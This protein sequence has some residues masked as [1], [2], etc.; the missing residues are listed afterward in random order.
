MCLWLQHHRFAME[1]FEQVFEAVRQVPLVKQSYTTEQLDKQLSAFKEVVDSPAQFMA[2]HNDADMQ[3]SLQVSMKA[4]GVSACVVATVFKHC[5][6]ISDLV[7]D[8]DL[9]A[10]SPPV[11]QPDQPQPQAQPALTDVTGLMQFLPSAANRKQL[12]QPQRLQPPQ[13][14]GDPQPVNDAVL[15][16]HVC[17]AST[18][19]AS[20][21]VTKIKQDM[22]EDPNIMDSD[23]SHPTTT[24]RNMC[25]QPPFTADVIKKINLHCI[26]KLGKDV[27]VQLAA[28][29]SFLFRDKKDVNHTRGL[30]FSQLKNGIGRVKGEVAKELALK[31]NKLY[32]LPPPQADAPVQ[33]EEE[34]EDEQGRPAKKAKNEEVAQDETHLKVYQNKFSEGVSLPRDEVSLSV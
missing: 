15:R 18:S 5:K 29:H 16:T 17:A 28:F 13:P 1:T 33:H 7:A 11:Q 32:N 31:S 34:Q 30:F 2:M 4:A 20:A 23:Y 14:Q 12:Q 21:M 19:I 8:D 22:Q 26:Q 3:L 27:S 10:A 9:Q 25:L 6:T 24:V